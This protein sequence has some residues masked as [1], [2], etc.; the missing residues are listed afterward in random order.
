MFFAKLSPENVCYSSH[1]KEGSDKIL[2]KNKSLLKVETYCKKYNEK[3]NYGEACDVTFYRFFWENAKFYI[4]LNSIC[5]INIFALFTFLLYRMYKHL[6]VHNIACKCLMIAIIMC[7]I[8]CIS[9]I[10]SYRNKYE[11]EKDQ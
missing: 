3:H 10:N 8:S 9:L 2:Y 5:F 7:M 11:Q 1:T 6:P 4:V